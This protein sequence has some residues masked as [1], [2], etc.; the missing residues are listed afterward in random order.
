MRLTFFKAIVLK[1]IFDNPCVCDYTAATYGFQF[2]CLSI[3]SCSC[4]L[5][6]LLQKA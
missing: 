3:H 1:K 4:F 5:F 2:P 6:N